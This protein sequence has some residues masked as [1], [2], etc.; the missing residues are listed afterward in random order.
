[1]VFDPIEPAAALAPSKDAALPPR[2]LRT[3]LFAGVR[4]DALRQ[5]DDALPTLAQLVCEIDLFMIQEETLVEPAL[6]RKDIR[7][8]EHCSSDHQ[9][10][11]PLARIVP[12]AQFVTVGLTAKKRQLAPRRAA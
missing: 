9:V 5:E 10:H 8:N 7:S 6:L 4:D 1:M 2:Y 12:L 3:P 11:V